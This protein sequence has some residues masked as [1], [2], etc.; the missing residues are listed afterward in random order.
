MFKDQNLFIRRPTLPQEIHTLQF[1]FQM[2]FLIPKKTQ[3]LNLKCYMMLCFQ[4]SQ[5]SELFP[6]LLPA[7]AEADAEVDKVEVEYF[8]N[9]SRTL[10]LSEQQT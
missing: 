6:Y 8:R 2:L 5:P 9:I 3:L 7:S 4:N 1:H 10:G